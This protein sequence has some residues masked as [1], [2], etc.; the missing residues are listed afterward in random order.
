MNNELDLE[1][2]KIKKP[3]KVLQRIYDDPTEDNQDINEFKFD[4]GIKDHYD[5]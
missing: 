1:T 3:V 2:K 4:H 5:E